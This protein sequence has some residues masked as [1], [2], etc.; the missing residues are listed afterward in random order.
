[1]TQAVW[2][3]VMGLAAPEI[4]MMVEDGWRV[5]CVIDAKPFGTAVLMRKEDDGFKPDAFF[6]GCLV[7]AVIAAGVAWWMVQ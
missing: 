7:G 1:M 4:K 6:I 5:E 3:E 2:I